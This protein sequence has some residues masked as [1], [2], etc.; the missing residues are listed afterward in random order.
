MKAAS[1]F[2]IAGMMINMISKTENKAN[3][4]GTR[5]AG[6]AALAAGLTTATNVITME[7]LHVAKYVLTKPCLTD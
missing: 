1:I 5:A 7:G 6:H 3:S 4:M 2:K